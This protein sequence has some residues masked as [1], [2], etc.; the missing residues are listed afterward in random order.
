MRG[1]KKIYKSGESRRRLRLK[2]GDKVIVVAGADK[3]KSGEVLRTDDKTGR[4][5]VHGVN[6]RTKHM[7]KT[8]ENPQGGV[9][10]KEFPVD[11]SNLMLFS[12]KAK[13]GVRVRYEVR[14]GKKVR[15]GTCGTVFQ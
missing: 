10:K 2:R 14:D 13:K 8:Q 9:T 15:V 4:V 5:L 11:A 7:R 6:V 3:G 1:K 12:D